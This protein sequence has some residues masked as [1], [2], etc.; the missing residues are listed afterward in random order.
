MYLGEVAPKSK[1]GFL[2]LIPSIHICFGVF[3]AQ[4]LGLSELLGK[5]PPPWP[6]DA[7]LFGHA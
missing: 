2:G 7:G 5:V 6:L 3:L 1:R 4:V